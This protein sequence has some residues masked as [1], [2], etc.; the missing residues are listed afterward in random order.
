MFPEQR[1]KIFRS[2]LYGGAATLLTFDVFFLLKAVITSNFIPIVPILAGVFTASGL[3]VV[4]YAEHY[5]RQQD[6]QEHRRISRV[7]HQLESP[8]HALRDDFDYLVKESTGLPAE[9]KMK[10]KR[11]ESRTH[12][13][14]ENIR[15]VFLMLQAHEGPISKEPRVYDLCTLMHDIIEYEKK[16]ASARN[17]EIVHQSHCTRAPAKVD[18]NLFQIALRH[19]V[20]NAITY[21]LTPGLV[22]ISITRSANKI[23]ITVQDR[24]V[25]IGQEEA[26]AM[27]QPFARGKHADQFDPDGIGV[28]LTLSRLIIRE[29]GG[30]IVYH[31]R[32]DS[33]GSQFEIHLPISS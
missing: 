3:L 16:V 32:T 18:R 21:T 7:A 14:L 26:R 25:G 17:V 15:D 1:E 9:L 23:R 30:D 5:A 29:F 2:F 27:W 33:R 4:V 31:D 12:T 6:K 28:G 19:L 11:M 8:L 22:A 13:L 24:G 10:L 20:N